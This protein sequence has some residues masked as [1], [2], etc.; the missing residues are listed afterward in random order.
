MERLKA[1]LHIHTKHSKDGDIDPKDLVKK[2]RELGFDVIGVTDHGTVRGGIETEKIAKKIAKS[3]IVF[4]GQEIKTK[5]GEILAYNV[6]KEIEEKQDLAKTCQD[7]KDG[8]LVIPHPFDLMRKGTRK[9]TKAI[10]RHVDALEVFNA[11]TIVNRFNKKAMEF[12]RE[13]KIPM[14]AGSD[15]H[16]L[17]EFGKT[18]ML[19]ESRR[20]KRDIL[21]AIKNRK[22]ELI[23]QGTDMRSGLKRG[24]RKIRTYF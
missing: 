24:L 8:F 1:D 10:L 19:I 3:L 7:A 5:Q 16:F 6:R 20:N 22:A 2:A 21:N 15:A 12:A 4:V 14:F 9:K 23:M 17:R 11:R 18:Y 13:N